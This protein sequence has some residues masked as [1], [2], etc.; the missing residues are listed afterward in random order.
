M[1]CDKKFHAHFKAYLYPDMLQERES[2]IAQLISM[3][4]DQAS[5]CSAPGG[6]S[7]RQ[8]RRRTAV[9]NTIRAETRDPD[10]AKVYLI[11]PPELETMV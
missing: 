2:I 3:K 8:L 10:D 4:S 1:T 6:L 5:G 7:D 11:F 9:Q